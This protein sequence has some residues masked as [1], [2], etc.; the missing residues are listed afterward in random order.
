MPRCM[1]LEP[2]LGAEPMLPAPQYLYH[3]MDPNF[4]F[5]AKF[6]DDVILIFKKLRRSPMP[7][8]H[9]CVLAPPSLCDDRHSP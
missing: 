9:S 7:L 8:V 4:E 6:E 1:Y 3:M 2:W 5:S